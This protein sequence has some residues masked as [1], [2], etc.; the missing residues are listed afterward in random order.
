MMYIYFLV[1]KPITT[2]DAFASLGILQNC[3]PAVGDGP[4]AAARAR[5]QQLALGKQ[6]CGSVNVHPNIS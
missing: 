2:N 5:L 6:C 3:G 1:F 4:A